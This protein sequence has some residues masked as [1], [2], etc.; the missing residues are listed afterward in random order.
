V[1]ALLL[2]RHHSPAFNRVTPR[3]GRFTDSRSACPS[4]AQ[5]DSR[6]RQ[7]ALPN[8]LMPRGSHPASPARLPVSQARPAHAR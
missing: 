2:P 7:I 5:T 6:P 4:H 3:P 8:R 1:A